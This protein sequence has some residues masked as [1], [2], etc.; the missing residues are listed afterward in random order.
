MS[1]GDVTGQSCEYHTVHNNKLFNKMGK[2]RLKE[3]LWEEQRSLADLIN[4]QILKCLFTEV[5]SYKRSDV[6]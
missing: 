3:D 2:V 4:H 1:G 6:N 5:N